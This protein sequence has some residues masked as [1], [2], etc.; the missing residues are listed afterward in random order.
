LRSGGC[1]TARYPFAVSF[2]GD[3]HPEFK[4]VLAEANRRIR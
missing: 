3:A 2:E 1:G 4:R